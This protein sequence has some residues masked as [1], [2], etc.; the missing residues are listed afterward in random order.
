MIVLVSDPPPAGW[1]MLPSG[2]TE[3]DTPP[4]EDVAADGGD[5]PRPWNKER[6]VML[7]AGLSA[8]LGSCS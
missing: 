4:T 2:E 3:L 6:E 8:H 7:R 5:Q 1:T